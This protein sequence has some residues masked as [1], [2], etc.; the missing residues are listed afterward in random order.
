MVRQSVRKRSKQISIQ[1]EI[2]SHLLATG[3]NPGASRVALVMGKAQKVLAAVTGL[4]KNAP[5][6]I[7]SADFSES[8][9]TE[10]SGLE[11]YPFSPANSQGVAFGQF[12]L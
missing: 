10:I 11:H 3:H 7:V 6:S 5:S 1:L 9:L 4:V 2:C 8:R 12:S